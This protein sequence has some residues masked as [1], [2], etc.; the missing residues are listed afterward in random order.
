MTHGFMWQIDPANP[1]HVHIWCLCSKW[2]DE[3]HI[4]VPLEGPVDQSVAIYGE[5][6]FQWRTHL[7]EAYEIE[8]ERDE[9]YRMD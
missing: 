4:A 9:H 1:A 2:W 7:N 5:G 6:A 3:F 8:R